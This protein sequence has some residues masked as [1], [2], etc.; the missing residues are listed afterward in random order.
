MK[1]FDCRSTV[2]KERIVVADLYR[3]SAIRMSWL[4]FFF[5]VLL[6]LVLAVVRILLWRSIFYNNVFI[7]YCVAAVLIWMVLDNLITQKIRAAARFL[8]FAETELFGTRW[9]QYLCGSKSLPEEVYRK[10]K[11]GIPDTN[12][13]YPISFEGMSENE[14]VLAC[15]NYN[16]CRDTAS[17]VRLRRTALWMMSVAIVVIVASSLLVTA[18]NMNATMLY[19]IVPAVPLVVWYSSVIHKTSSSL[20]QLSMIGLIIKDAKGTNNT[21]FNN[22]IQDYLFVYNKSKYPV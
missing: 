6:V 16:V 14:K 8:Q 4:R 19:I 2:F 12:D 13:R 9:N 10:V 7:F 15:Y 5:C 18:S 20:E 21:E 1:P 17:I 22:L 11:K 3:R